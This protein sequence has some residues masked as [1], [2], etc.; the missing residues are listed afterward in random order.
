M[1]GFEEEVGARSDVSLC[2]SSCSALD[3]SINSY[4]IINRVDQRDLHQRSGR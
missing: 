4:S 3:L 2:R 1:G